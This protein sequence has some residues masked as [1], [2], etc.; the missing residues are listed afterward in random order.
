MGERI[1]LNAVDNNVF[2]C[3]WLVTFE[4]PTFLQIA[5]HAHSLKILGGTNVILK[6]D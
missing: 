5:T 1:I 2:V 6:G 3:F 4:L